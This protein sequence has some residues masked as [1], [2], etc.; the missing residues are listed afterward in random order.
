MIRHRR[1]GLVVCNGTLNVLVPGSHAHDDTS[2]HCCNWSAVGLGIRLC[3]A[4]PRGVRYQP[5][6]TRMSAEPDHCSTFHLPGD[7]ADTQ[8]H[9]HAFVFVC[10]Y[11]DISISG[12][13][14]LHPHIARRTVPLSLGTQQ[15][16]PLVDMQE[17]RLTVFT[18]WCIHNLGNQ[19]HISQ[20]TVQITRVIQ[21]PQTSPEYILASSA[22]AT[23]WMKSP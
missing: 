1:S 20:E 21:R 23:S 12:I 6:W 10:P 19:I 3:N 5:V 13:K 8:H 15:R 14:R 22:E 16:Q 2:K 7:A 4:A 9:F 11:L 17:L 18:R